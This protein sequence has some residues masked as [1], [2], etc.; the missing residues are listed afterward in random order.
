MIL[1]KCITPESWGKGI[2]MPI[3]KNRWS[4]SDPNSNR[5]VTLNSYKMFSAVLNNRLTKFSDEFELI[6]YLK[7]FHFSIL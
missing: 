3:F 5:E 4:K 1:D 6:K 2:F 7:T